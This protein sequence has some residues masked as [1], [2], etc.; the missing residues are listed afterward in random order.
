MSSRDSRGTGGDFG[1]W[2]SG[3][4]DFRLRFTEVLIIGSQYFLMNGTNITS[5]ASR[6]RGGRRPLRVT[7]ENICL[8]C[9]TIRNLLPS[10]EGAHASVRNPDAAGTIM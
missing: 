6:K 1:S 2:G 10:A 5:R 9:P 3:C 7:M 8:K 4:C